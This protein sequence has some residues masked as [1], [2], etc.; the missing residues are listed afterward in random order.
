M[1]VDGGCRGCRSPAQS[2][3][4]AH[5]A[6]DG[7]QED[8][9]RCEQPQLGAVRPAQCSAHSRCRQLR[10]ASYITLTSHH[11]TPHSCQ[12][13]QPTT[14]VTPPVAP[15]TQPTSH[16]GYAVCVLTPRRPT[17]RLPLLMHCITSDLHT[18]PTTLSH[19]TLPAPCLD[20]TRHTSP[21]HSHPPR[22]SPCT[23]ALAHT[24]ASPCHPPCARARRCCGAQTAVQSAAPRHSRRDGSCVTRSTPRM[25]A[26]TTR[27]SSRASR[28]QGALDHHP[29]PPV[30]HQQ[31]RHHASLSPPAAVAGRLLR[32]HAAARR[33]AASPSSIVA[34]PATTTTAP[35]I[36]ASAPLI[37]IS[38]STSMAI[39]IAI[40]FTTRIPSLATST[41]SSSEAA[42]RATTTFLP[43]SCAYSCRRLTAGSW[44]LHTRT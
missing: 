19:P 15:Q 28:L 42:S 43:S 26:S 23:D 17:P 4:V 21:H 9:P 20:S 11:S 36:V 39:G 2:V 16:A 29:A 33:G 38:A 24:R 37:L 7:D 32:T 18:P 5:D 31:P 10:G 30:A 22:I 12:Q 14:A 13:Q 44:E 1:T 3:D 6:H 8:A 27:A 35:A 40:G 25:A 34:A 41:A